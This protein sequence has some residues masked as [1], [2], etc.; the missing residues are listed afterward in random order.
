M[1]GPVRVGLTGG[2]GSGKTTVG[3]MLAELGAAVVD[4]DAIARAVTAPRGAAI[5]AIAAAFGA[6]F[7]TPEGALDRDRMRTL[8][9]T[10]PAARSR[11]EGIVHPLVGAETEAQAQAALAA[12]RRVI[13]F[14]V[15]LLVETGRWRQKVDLVLVVDASEATR[16][17]RVMQRSNLPRETVAGIIASQATREQRLAAADIVIC[18]DGIPLEALRSE[19]A[20][21]ARRFGL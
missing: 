14:D 6:E 9:Y 4:S 19:V 11:L 1:R 8:A 12:G 15:P 13:V 16:T 2:I 5:P 17:A 7:I 21:A 10:D 3:Q 20:L 18:N